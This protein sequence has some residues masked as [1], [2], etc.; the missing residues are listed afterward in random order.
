MYLLL[1]DVLIVED[2]DQGAGGVEYDVLDA[3]TQQDH[4]DLNNLGI[5]EGLEEVLE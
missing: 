4:N 2:I 5:F 1:P 3:V